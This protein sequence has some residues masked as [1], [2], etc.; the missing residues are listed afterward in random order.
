MKKT[1]AAFE[2][3]KIH[4]RFKIAALWTSVM[5]CYIY[6]DY[7]N[8]FQPGS[9][10]EMLAGRMGPLGPVTQGV[11][12]GTAVLL[13]IPSIMIFLSLVLRPN[14]NRWLNIALGVIYTI[15]SFLTMPGSWAYYML[16]AAIEAV[17]TLLV[18]WYAW[19]WPK[20]PAER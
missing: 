17:L 15:I 6:N 14:L 12:F 11:L 10:R 9:L 8:L 7:F 13:A 20:A 1:V 5:F 4:A 2:D 16:Y 19:T 18:V 3:V